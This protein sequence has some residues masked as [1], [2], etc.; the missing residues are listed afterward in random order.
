M[1]RLPGNTGGN[2]FVITMSKNESPSHLT[3]NHTS[4]INHI[5]A[6]PSEVSREMCVETKRQ[7]E[8]VQGLNFSELEVTQ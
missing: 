6:T 3:Q 8:A 5:G 1:H 7:V 4:N 2:A